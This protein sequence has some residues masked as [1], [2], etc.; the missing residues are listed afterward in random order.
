MSL[1]PPL[2]QNRIISSLSHQTGGACDHH[3]R[4]GQTGSWRPASLLSDARQQVTRV[5]SCRVGVQVWNSRLGLASQN[6]IK[7]GISIH[8]WRPESYPTNLKA[9]PP[10]AEFGKGLRMSQG[11]TPAPKHLATWASISFRRNPL[12][13]GRI[14]WKLGWNLDHSNIE[15]SEERLCKSGTKLRTR[16]KNRFHWQILLLYCFIWLRCS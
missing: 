5:T 14:S 8:K 1:C 7:L 10:L 13:D 4:R 16:P 2:A 12:A 3:E 15:Y 6:P 11:S 9:V